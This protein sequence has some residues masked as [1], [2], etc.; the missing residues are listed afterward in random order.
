MNIFKF[1]FFIKAHTEN[2]KQ[3][4]NYKKLIE[5]I[6]VVSRD[7]LRVENETWLNIHDELKVYIIFWK[8]L[9]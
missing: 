4:N 8:R 7:A 5:E 2:I 1:F 6:E 9:I 3:I